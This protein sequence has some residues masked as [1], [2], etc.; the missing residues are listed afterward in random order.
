MSQTQLYSMARSA[1]VLS[2]VPDFHHWLTRAEQH[3]ADAF[4]SATARSDFIAGHL[5]ARLVAAHFTPTS[6]S[7]LR[8]IQHCACC[9]G[10]HGLPR[11]DGHP[12]LHIS[13]SHTEGVA[14]AVA[15]LHPV[16][17]DIETLRDSERLLEIMPAALATAELARIRHLQAMGVSSSSTDSDAVERALLRT[18]VRKEAFVKLGLLTLDTLQ[19]LDLSA[20][21]IEP[22]WVNGQTWSTEY[23]A[24]QLTDFVAPKLGVA[25]AVLGDD[26]TAWI[27]V[28]PTQT[29]STVG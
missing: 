2:A 28:L 19:S 29:T 16:A 8:L 24:R 20:L 17:I 6:A 15:G 18:W 12:E 25:G 4:L 10:A 22:D 3:R 11:L 21:A 5:L 23:N 27:A 13:I 1:D 9:G 26:V 14:A 7:D